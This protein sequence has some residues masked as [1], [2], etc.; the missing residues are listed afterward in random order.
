MQG[1]RSCVRHDGPSPKY[2]ISDEN[3]KLQHFD[4]IFRFVAV[5]AL[6]GNLWTKKVFFG[7]QKQCLLGKKGTI[8]W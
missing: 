1:G 3:F 5:F 2:L 8:T 4:A 6:F 7:G